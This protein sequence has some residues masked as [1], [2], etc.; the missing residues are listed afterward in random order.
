MKID[1]VFEA[2]DGEGGKSAVDL[3]E[4]VE[5]SDDDLAV[6][7]LQTVKRGQRTLG[8]PDLEEFALDGI[9]DGAFDVHLRLEQIFDVGGG[10]PAAT[11]H[12]PLIDEMCRK[13]ENIAEGSVVDDVLVII[14]RLYDTT[15]IT[16]EET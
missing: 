3:E 11:L 4:L 13:V 2:E 8:I 16:V 6:D 12:Q 1:R 9:V 14:I 10:N 15:D 7:E 5:V